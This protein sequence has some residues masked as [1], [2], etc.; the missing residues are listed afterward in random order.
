MRRAIG[1]LCAVAIVAL[2]TAGLG[3]AGGC[4]GSEPTDEADGGT[5]DVVDA[6]DAGETG[7]PIDTR[8]ADVDATDA[9]D[10]IPAPGILCE[11]CSDDSECGESGDQCV[12]LADGA[13]VCA[14]ACD[15]AESSP[16]PDRFQ[17]ASFDQDDSTGQCIPDQL[18][19]KD[20]CSGVECG[21]DRQCNPLN[22]ECEETLGYCD[23]GCQ[24]D[25]MCGDGPEDR[26]LPLPNTRNPREQIC[27]TTCNPESEDPGC[28]VDFACAALAPDEDPTSGICYPLERTCVDRCSETSCPEGQNCN[29]QTGECEEAQYSACQKGCSSNAQC[30]DQ[31]DWCL[32]L[33]IGEGSHC[34]LGCDGGSQDCP[35]NYS[36]SQLR[37]T[38]VNICI[39]DSMRCNECYGN[40]CLPGGACNPETGQCETLDC[41]ETGCASDEA[42]DPRSTSCVEVGRSCSGG[43]WAAD[44]DNIVTGCTSRRS[45][46]DGTCE[47]ICSSNADCSGDTSCVSTNYEDFCLADDLGGP[48]TC[49][50]LHRAGTDVGSGCSSSSD[51]SGSAPTC[52]TGAGIDGFCSRSCTSDSDCSANQV[53]AE[54]PDGSRVCTPVQCRCAASLGAGSAVRSA[55]HSALNSL[56]LD[57]CEV[58]ANPSEA[59]SLEQLGD[60]PLAAED[61]A[62]WLEFPVAGIRDAASVGEA[63]ETP[64]DSPEVALESAADAAGVSISPQ[65]GNYSFSGS[66]SK[67][68][69]AASELFRAAGQTPPTSTLQSKAQNVPSDFQDVAAPI[70]MAVADAYRAREQA[71]QSAGWGSTRRSEAFAG[72][73]YLFL[74]GTQSL[75]GQAPDLSNQNVVQDYRDFPTKEMA[76]AAADLAATISD[77]QSNVSNPSSWTGFSYVVDTNAGKIVLGDANDTTYDPSTNSSYSGDIA[78]LIDAGGNDTYR[79]AAGANTSVANGAAVAVDLG[80]EDTYSYEKVGDSLDTQYLLTSDG[81]GR[82]SRSARGKGPISLSENSRQGAGRVGIGLLVDYGTAQDTYESLRMSQGAAVFGVGLLY[83]EGGPDSFSSEALSQGAALGGLG[84]VWAAGSG[85]DD[86]EVWHAGQGFGSGDGTGVL[87]DRGGDDVYTAVRGN[88]NGDGVVYFSQV[89]T[90]SSNRN[91]AQGAGAGV[92]S[93]SNTV[94][95]GGGLGILRDASGGDTYK[96]ATYAQGY[97]TVRGVG[98]LSDAGG[99]D[100]YGARGYVQ[101]AGRLFGGGLLDERGGDDTYNANV[102][103]RRLGQGIGERYG[104]GG[105]VERGGGDDITYGNPGGGFGLDGGFGFAIEGDGEDTH[106]LGSQSGWGYATNTASAGDPLNDVLTFGVFLDVG[107]DSD[108]YQ[109]PQISGSGIGDGSSWLQPDPPTNVEKGAGVDQ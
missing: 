95:L 76:K 69:Q 105:F 104:W 16:C 29:L 14:T 62:P 17:C 3:I 67:L 52:V 60:T 5:T 7:E 55:F 100:T 19:C 39:P 77:A 46:I 37:G 91:L 93:S 31:D 71:L 40:S 11:P 59:L 33:G 13:S 32:N 27:T 99:A 54:G 38:T 92:A 18:T 86:Y 94:G 70:I 4:G 87:F 43:S 35:D 102:S 73:P 68:T 26:C 15:P 34:W 45:G 81:D 90:G 53:C 56:G 8:E 82:E 36:C 10:G 106:D 57:L 28:P 23:N 64:S 89:N 75:L 72:A 25:S 6:T 30:G 22:G 2:G 44:C 41:T 74:P 42:C 61:L 24:I 108:T 9:G 83:D 58:R 20:R 50:S 1:R 78:V 109:R 85:G 63:V 88:S 97:G 101:G 103:T 80:G 49:G 98:V 66:N 96:A 107:G 48:Q 21:E 65:A 51:C 47:R 12:E 79:V 84:V